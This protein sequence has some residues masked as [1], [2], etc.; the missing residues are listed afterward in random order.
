MSEPAVEIQEPGKFT[1]SSPDD[2]VW[3]GAPQPP[4][5][6]ATPAKPAGPRDH[7]GRF[8]DHGKRSATTLG[9]EIP[10]G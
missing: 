9:E 2:L 8:H 6:P 5:R 3:D 1:W 10:E 4:D 7:T